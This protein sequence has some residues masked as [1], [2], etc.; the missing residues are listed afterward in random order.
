MRRHDISFEFDVD[1]PLLAKSKELRNAF[2]RD[3]VEPD[4][5]ALRPFKSRSRDRNAVPIQQGPYRMANAKNPYYQGP[6][7]DHFDGTRFFNPNGIEPLGL[8]ALLRW[9]F[10]GERKRWQ[11]EVPSPFPPAKP[12]PRLSGDKVAVLLPTELRGAP[13]IS[14]PDDGAVWM[15]S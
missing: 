13:Q 8:R 14:I 15:P 11:K 1:H 5:Q 10:N 4:E 2:H 3:A 9:Q 7:P 12:A 6:V